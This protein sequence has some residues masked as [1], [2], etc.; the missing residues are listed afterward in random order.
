MHLYRGT[1]V[2]IFVLSLLAL[3]SADPVKKSGFSIEPTSDWVVRN[4]NLPFGTKVII[5]APGDDPYGPSVQVMIQPL[6]SQTIEGF[7]ERQKMM[8]DESVDG[9]TFAQSKLAGQPAGMYSY[10]VG[11]LKTVVR[12]VPTKEQVFMVACTARIKEFEP[13]EA[14]FSKIVESFSLTK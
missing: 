1:V 10:T 14:T 11:S 9:L 2:F 12:Y 13:S 4:E 8:L 5:E 6:G 3:V 7:Y